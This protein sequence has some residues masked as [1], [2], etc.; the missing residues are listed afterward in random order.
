[1]YSKWRRVGGDRLKTASFLLRKEKSQVHVNVG[2]FLFSERPG[3][4]YSQI[5][6]S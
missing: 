3:D 5:P 4:K 6:V 2:L 1:M